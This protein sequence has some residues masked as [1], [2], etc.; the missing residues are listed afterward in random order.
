MTA[1][2]V[3]CDLHTVVVVSIVAAVSAVVRHVRRLTPPQHRDRDTAATN[4][5]TDVCM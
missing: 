4:I 1:T 3:V 5:A 2:T